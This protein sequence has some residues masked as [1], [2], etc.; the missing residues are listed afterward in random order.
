MCYQHGACFLCL[1]PFQVG[2]HKGKLKRG[3]GGAPAPELASMEEQ[4]GTTSFSPLTNS[5]Q[6]LKGGYRFT[7]LLLLLWRLVLA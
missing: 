1:P 5:T 6:H 4:V 2:L 7:I 3:A